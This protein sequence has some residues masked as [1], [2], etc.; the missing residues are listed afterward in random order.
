MDFGSG[1]LMVES[2]GEKWCEIAEALS[3]VVEVGR[4]WPSSDQL[5]DHGAEI[6]ERGDRSHGRRVV[7]SPRAPGGGEQESGVDNFEGDLAVVESRGEAAVGAPGEAGG[8]GS[9]SVE[10]EDA[11]DILRT[12]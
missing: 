7:G 8:A 6:V 11:F 10:V 5:L 1:K 12:W 4:I 2:R 9:G 3:E